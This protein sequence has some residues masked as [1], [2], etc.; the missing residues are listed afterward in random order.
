MLFGS[1]RSAIGDEGA[2][3]DANHP[4]SGDCLGCHSTTPTFATNQS[5]NAK[6][7]NHIPTSAPSPYTTAPSCA[8]CHTTVGNNSVYSVAAVH[9]NLAANSCLT[10]HKSTVSSTFANVIIKTTPGNHIPIGA[11]DCASSGC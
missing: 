8:T 4:A 5:G 9:Q 11:L 7:A 3:Y 2:T 1:S 6:P 10:C